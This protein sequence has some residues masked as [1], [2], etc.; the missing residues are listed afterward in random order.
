MTIQRTRELLAE[1]T[2]NMT[3]EEVVKLIQ[4]TDD[5]VTALFELSVKESIANLK[6]K[7]I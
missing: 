6:T 1:E 4:T 2:S 3:D 5:A 7:G